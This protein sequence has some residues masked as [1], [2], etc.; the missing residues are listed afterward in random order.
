[1]N[2]DN[3]KYRKCGKFVR[4]PLRNLALHRN[5]NGD[6]L[7]YQTPADATCHAYVPANSS[8]GETVRYASRNNLS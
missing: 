2:T 8:P 5:S 4:I 1:M 7:E 3:H 6:F